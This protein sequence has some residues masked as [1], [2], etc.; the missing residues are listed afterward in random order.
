LLVQATV[1]VG[2]RGELLFTV[3]VHVGGEPTTT[4]AG[5]QVTEVVDDTTEV[6]DDTAELKGK[7]QE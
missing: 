1:P 3:A 4:D 5:E 2:L 7:T 6:V